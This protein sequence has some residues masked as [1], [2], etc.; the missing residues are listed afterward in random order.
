MQLDTPIASL[1]RWS[2]QSGYSIFHTDAE[3]TDMADEY[4]QI[5]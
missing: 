1:P 5:A 2:V 4:S 3:E